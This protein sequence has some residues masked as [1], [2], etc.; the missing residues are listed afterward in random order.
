MANQS[1]W[2]QSLDKIFLSMMWW[3]IPM[4]IIIWLP[5]TRP[6]WWVFLAI[7]LSIELKKLYLWWIAWDFAYAETEWDFI[8]IVPPKEILTPLKAMEDVFTSMWSPLFDGA[9]WRE[10]WCEGE[11]TEV[12]YWMSLEIVSTEG[13]IHFY[14]RVMRAHRP[15]LESILY[16]HYP[17]LEIF[18]T[19]DYTSS[20]PN[21]L[22]NKE[23]DTYGED[24]VL[25]RPDPYPIKT[26]ENFF[27]PQGE[28]IVGE[29]KRIDPINSLL[30]SMAKLGKGEHYWVQF[31]LMG[32]AD[33][34]EPKFK[35]D[36][37][38][39]IAKLAKRPAPKKPRTFA[40][41][42]G[43]MLNDIVFGP[44][45][46]GEGEYATYKW[47]RP[48][49]KEEK[50]G[51]EA[52][53]TPGERDVLTAVENKIKKPLYRTSIR[54]VYV[55][56]RENFNK[57]NRVIFRPYVTHFLT[58]NLNFIGFHLGTRPKVHYWFRKMRVRFRA[59]RMLRN[60]ILRFPP[61][62]PNRREGCSIFNPEE[63][64]TMYHFPLKISSTF[65]PSMTRVES[66]K[67]GAPSNLPIGE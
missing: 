20:V 54:G 11:L 24:F 18:D 22:P 56:K 49:E 31:T 61:F 48:D 28:R 58:R 7:F 25:K 2:V 37:E 62:F 59:R 34:F 6:F 15:F 3:L 9:N 47:E 29:E 23:W 38:E 44:N 45:K 17:E 32:T 39:I 30:E 33:N 27:E 35:K 53:L 60:Y 42:L 52:S 55:A 4:T 5:F 41:E 65:L 64:A 13:E 26:Y 57:S 43:F 46:E 12:P 50:P 1:S 63:I 51:K 67:G 40:G 14:A 19:Q 66:K 8:E 36:A 16:S 10:E 21:N